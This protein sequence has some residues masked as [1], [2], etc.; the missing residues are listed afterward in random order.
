MDTW[1]DVWNLFYSMIQICIIYNYRYTKT[2]ARLA[3]V[4]FIC[5]ESCS[6]NFT[7]WV[8]LYL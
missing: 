4:L 5:F 3:I 6:Q 7:L 8:H 1:I 2:F